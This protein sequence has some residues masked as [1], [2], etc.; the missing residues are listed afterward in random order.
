[1]SEEKIYTFDA[2]T[3]A[4]N[5]GNV[6]IN[7]LVWIRYNPIK[8]IYMIIGLL[9]TVW[10][11]LSFSFWF[12]ILTAIIL[13]L[14]I[15]YWRR[16]FEHFK[17]GDSNGGIIISTNPMLVAVTTDLTMGEGEFPVI[18]IIEYKGK[19]RVGDRI[20]TVALY[21]RSVDPNLPHWA[22]FNPLPVNYVSN[23]LFK[24]DQIVRSYDSAQWIQIESRME[25]IQ[26]PYETGLYHIYEENSDWE[27]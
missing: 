16:L 6:R 24:M 10:L 5:P 9:V 19:G 3:E 11:A 8:P 18:K 12:F 27:R 20:G 15:I 4:S 22:D 23:D 26:Q 7:P 2:N 17:H 14:K 25:G 13:V 21:Y 1:M